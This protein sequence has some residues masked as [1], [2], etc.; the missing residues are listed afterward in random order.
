MKILIGQIGHETNTFAVDR[1]DVALFK[2]LRWW[3]GEELMQARGSSDYLAGMI[4]VAEKMGAE[5][6]PAFAAFQTSGLILRET[7][8]T[9]R[10]ELCARI[11]QHKDEL[12]G[13]CIS[14][15]GAAVAEGAEDL[16]LDL[17]RYIRSI[18]GPEMPI[19]ATFDLH[20]NISK[21]LVDLLDCMV[22]VKE[23]PHVDCRE[24][25]AKGMEL[26]IGKIRGTCRPV[27]AYRRIPMLIPPAMGN[28]FSAPAKDIK[29]YLAQYAAAHGLLDISFFHGFPYADLP[30]AGSSIIVTADGDTA[31]AEAAAEELAHYIWDMRHEFDSHYLT[32]AQA[33]DRA[34]AV[35]GGPVV[36]NE[37]S[38]NPGGGTPADG[39]HLL[40]ELLKRNLP[41]TCF[42]FIYDPEFVRL[43][44]EAGVGATV[45]GLLGGKTD[46]IHGEPLEVTGYVKCITDGKFISDSPALAKGLPICVGPCVRVIIGNVDVV[47]GSVR[48]QTLDDRLFLLHGIDVSRYKILGL[49]SCMHFRASFEPLAKAIV[50]ADPPGIHTANF[51]QLPYSRL[52][53]PIY[54][55]DPDTQ[56]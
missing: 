3:E 41:Q 15:H 17:V 10:E 23:Y 48:F 52:T 55:L 7:Y 18:V 37:T 40:R 54:P 53:R 47:V 20:G 25:G 28:T 56:F 35:E 2:K 39:T 46:N 26:L 31:A 6:L 16:E 32:P 36:I 38:D 4:E 30:I 8:E 13:I 24:A 22:N 11:R 14:V 19:A 43:A 27:M 29:E 50:T 42:C 44:M 9:M 1:T 45:T 51:S 12:D 34:L 5:L 33:I 21:D 49:K